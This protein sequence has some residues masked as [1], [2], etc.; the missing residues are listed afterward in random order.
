MYLSRHGFHFLFLSV[1]TETMEIESSSFGIYERILKGIMVSIHCDNGHR[2]ARLL[3]NV[4]RTLIYLVTMNCTQV[5]AGCSFV[6]DCFW[7]NFYT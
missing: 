6:L 5:E 3:M 1:L 4:Y 7:F 2:Q